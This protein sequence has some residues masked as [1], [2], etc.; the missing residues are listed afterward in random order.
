[1]GLIMFMILGLLVGAGLGYKLETAP[2][3]AVPAVIGVTGGL[4]GGTGTAVLMGVNPLTTGFNLFTWLG[5]IA[6]AVVIMALFALIAAPGGSPT[7]AA[8][9]TGDRTTAR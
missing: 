1:M 6:G 7:H 3:A 5:A 8:T 9:G 4:F 2:R